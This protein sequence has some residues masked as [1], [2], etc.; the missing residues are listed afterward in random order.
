MF[1]TDDVAPDFLLEQGHLDNAVRVA[2]AHGVDPVLAI[3]AATVAP[4]E[5]LGLRHDIGSIAPGRFA[6]IL[7]V[8]DLRDFRAHRVLVDG[9]DIDS[10]AIGG[11]AVR[12]RYEYPPAARLSVRVP[13]DLSESDLRIPAPGDRARVRV[14]GMVD[15]V[16]PTEHLIIETTVL[17]GEVTADVSIDLAKVALVNRHGGAANSASSK[18]G[19]QVA[20]GFV[21]GLGLTGGAI[22]QS[23]ARDTHH[24]LAVGMNDSDMITAARAVIDDGGGIVEEA[25]AGLRSVVRALAGLGCAIEQP[26][27]MLAMLAVSAIPEL[28]IGNRGLIDSRDYRLVPPVVG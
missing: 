14:I 23:T 11:A 7:F 22:A 15:R 2:V 16:V 25:A 4:A 12:P 6:D 27:T 26:T 13:A 3:Q 18:A 24:L 10:A 1:I 8:N 17:D 28:R 20:L 21:R 9:G 5:Y 19:K